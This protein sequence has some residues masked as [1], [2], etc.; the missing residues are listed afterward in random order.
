MIIRNASPEDAAFI[1]T[2]ESPGGR[3]VARAYRC[4]AGVVTIGHGF[5]MGSKVFAAYWTAKHGRALRMGDTITQAESDDLL[6]RMIDEEYGAAVAERVKPRKQHHFGGAASMTFNCGPG[7]LGWRWAKALARRDVAEAAR[8][9]RVTAT[10]ANGRTLPGL[11]RR[12]KEEA[13]LIEHG[14]YLVPIPAGGGSLPKVGPD[15]EVTWIQEQLTALGY[16]PGTVDGIMG[17]K[18]RRAVKFFQIDAGLVVDGIPGPATRAAIIR[19]LDVK[20]QTKAT[21]GAAAAGGV[22]GAGT[23]VATA[24]DV[25]STDMLLSG[26]GWALLAA[27]VVAA[28]FTFYRNRGRLTG[29]RVPT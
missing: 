24:P 6:R 26:L 5:T 2:H 23:D 16:D 17:E 25:L 8:L 29:R 10:T 20:A 9:L 13:E 1:A 19:K 4:P 12:R 14:R 3:A 28:A 22:G 21:G 11:V 7:A 27:L 15:A 18:T